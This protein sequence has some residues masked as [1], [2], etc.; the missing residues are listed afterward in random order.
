MTTF[1]VR[2]LK[3]LFAAV[4]YRSGLLGLWWRTRGRRRRPGPLIVMYHRVLDPA[5][6]LDLSQAGIVVTAPTFE[7]QLGLLARWFRIVPLADAAASADPGLAAIT[8]DDG[9]ADNRTE[10]LPVLGRLALPATL[11]VTTGFMGSDRLF[12]PERLGHLLAG[13]ERRRLAPGALDGLRPAVSAALLAAARAS[14]A[15]LAAALDRLIEEAKAMGEEEREPMLELL[16]QKTG[17]APRRLA[18][19][20]LDWPGVA[21]M[22]RAGIEI[23]AHGV[24]HAILT[25]MEHSRAVAEIRDSRAAVAEAL[26]AP[27]ASF[28]YPNGNVSPELARAVKEAGYARAVVTE[29]QPPPGC[30]QGFALRRKNLAEGSSRGVRGFSAAIFACEVLGLFDALRATGMRRAE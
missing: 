15:A 28:A 17:R 21:E 23:G 29:D 5:V 27:P 9:W 14:A 22:Q 30:P 16:G 18:P 3:Q 11:F 7:R 10:A 1:V 25:R 2:A 26:G 8:F 6:G 24:T 12:W 19:R 20:L 4:L 13:A